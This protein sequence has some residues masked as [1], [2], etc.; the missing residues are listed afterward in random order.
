MTEKNTA[1]SAVVKGKVQGVGFRYSAFNAAQKLGVL[2][3]VRNINDGNV[4]VWSE[5]LP[6]A[7]EEFLKWLNKGPTY[8]RVD[9]VEVTWEKPTGRFHKFSI[10]Y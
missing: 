7:Q 1:F 10:E 3:W 9:L 5:G 4:E 2:G 6:S 8:A